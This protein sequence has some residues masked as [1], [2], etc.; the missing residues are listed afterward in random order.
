MRRTR[1]S[2][3]KPVEEMVLSTVMDTLFFFGGGLG[4]YALA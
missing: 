4:G 1:T 2:F 3:V